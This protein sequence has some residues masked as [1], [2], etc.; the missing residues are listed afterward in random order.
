MPTKQDQ[1]ELEE[2][3]N[4]SAKIESATFA[5]RCWTLVPSKI[6]CS[7]SLSQLSH[8][9]I[10][11]EEAVMAGI[12]EVF[13]DSRIKYVCIASEWEEGEAIPRLHVQILLHS[14]TKHHKKN[15]WLTAWVCACFIQL[16]LSQ[17]NE[18]DSL[19]MIVLFIML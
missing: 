4:S 3:K 8:V 12:I 7:F 2:I 1:M 5:I 6:E 10:F 14:K 11:V 9:E 13:Q 18:T 15:S 19:L 16:I 17:S